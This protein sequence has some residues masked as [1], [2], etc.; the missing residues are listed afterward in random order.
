MAHLTRETALASRLLA[1]HL[2]ETATAFEAFRGRWRAEH[3]QLVARAEVADEEAK[4]ALGLRAKRMRGEFLLGELARRGFTPAYGFPVDVVTFDHLSGSKRTETVDAPFAFGERRGG[5]SRT[6]DM[7]IREYAPGA[8]MV[9]DGLVHVSEGVLPAWSSGADASGLEDLQT[10][11]ECKRCRT[12]GLAVSAPEVCPACFNPSLERKRALRPA[13]FLGRKQ[14][15]TGYERLIYVPFEMPRVTARGGAWLSLPNG[16]SGRFRADPGGEVLTTSSG[17]NRVGYALCLACGRAEAETVERAGSSLPMPDSIRRH[18]P[19]ARSAQD[20]LVAGYCPGGSAQPGRIQANI[21]FAH[22]ARTDVFELQMPA[23]SSSGAALAL[24]AAL[25]EALCERLGADVR[26]IGVAVEMSEERRVSAMLHDRASGG[27]GL[28]ARLADIEWLMAVLDEARRR[29]ACPDD[30]ETGCPACVL[31]PD[32]NFAKPPLDRRG[33]LA[34]AAQLEPAFTLPTA[35]RVFGA[36]TRPLGTTLTAWLETRQRIAQLTAAT[37]WL[38]GAPHDWDLAAWPAKT[39]LGHLKERGAMIT[40]ALADAHLV[41]RALDMATKLSLHQLATLADLAHVRALPRTESGAPIMVTT[42]GPAGSLDIAALSEAEALPNEDWGRGAASPLVAGKA[43]T[44]P[45]PETFDTK[46]LVTLSA[47][48]A[49]LIRV[50][51]RLDGSVRDFG[52]RFW[53]LL[54]AEAPMVF[55][56]L[57]SARVKEAS[58]VDRYLASP[59]NFLLM[60]SVMTA[61]PGLAKNAPRFVRTAKLSSASFDHTFVYHDFGDDKLRREFLSALMPAAQLQ[62]APRRDMSHARYLLLTF[63]DGRQVSILLDQGFGAWKCDPLRHDFTA[64]AAE[65]ARRLNDQSFRVRIAEPN[66][67]PIIVEMT[68]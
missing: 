30:C 31:R 18:K 64:K 57:T 42:T 52:A 19:L 39:A 12:F 27:A 16:E 51:G 41:D 24:A 22:V 8:E 61:I 2:V 48:N 49:R 54:G 21:R 53:D 58:Y 45:K 67:S 40:L 10:L 29:L 66:G 20:K 59:L 65:Q 13:G 6:L 60:A 38:H 46:R 5:A 1:E 47:G 43:Q 26:E 28:V 14:P 11:W 34:L 9:V 3:T 50:A 56:A 37:I 68:T 55:G 4:A 35:N 62:F 23:G 17:P 63:A 25:R 36:Q 32:L 33:G 15:H 44:R 7:A